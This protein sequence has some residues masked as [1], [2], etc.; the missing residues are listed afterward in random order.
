MLILGGPGPVDRDGNTSDLRFD[1]YRTVA[2]ALAE[3]GFAVL[4]Y[5]KRGVGQSGG[6]LSLAT[7]NDF[8]GDAEAALGALAKAASV[9]PEALSIVGHSEGGVIGGILA[10]REP[11]L[12]SLA[13][14][15][16]PAQPLDELLLRQ[17]RETARARGVAPED[18]ERETE[19]R[20]KHFA[21]IK[22]S[23]E[24]WLEIGGAKVFV[25]WLRE[26]FNHD[27]VATLK[28]VKAAVIVAQGNRDRVVFPDN[29][30]V[31]DRAL[32]EAAHPRFEMMKFEKLDHLFVESEEGAI[33]RLAE[34][35][36]VDRGFVEYLVDALR[37]HGKK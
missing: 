35:R 9:D 15:A 10:T 7:L 12:K 23:K 18:I 1:L 27:V 28:R 30:D 3:A 11:K 33:A 14:L 17:Y 24:D 34:E 13:L 20:R 2:Y 37:R 22:A 4:R 31:V 19:A 26:H 6:N 5:D 29:A 25:G 16:S 36:P 21:Q 8:V 32:K